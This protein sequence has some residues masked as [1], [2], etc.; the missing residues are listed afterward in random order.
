MTSQPNWPPISAV[1]THDA[2]GFIEVT[3]MTRLTRTADTP[4]VTLC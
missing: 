3:D 4:P 2:G 1:F